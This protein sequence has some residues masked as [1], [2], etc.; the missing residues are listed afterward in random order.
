MRQYPEALLTAP[1]LANLEERQRAEMLASAIPRTLAKG[2]FLFHE[3]DR[4]ECFFVLASGSIKLVRFTPQGKEML[5][6]MVRPGQTFAEA[7]VFGP[8]TYP[9]TA[10]AVELCE[11]WMWPLDRLLAML[12]GTPELALALILSVSVWTRHLVG[13]LEFLTQ[14]R[15]E[16]RLAVYL[17][18][19]AGGRRLASGDE[20]VL[21]EAKQLI[22]AQIGTAP[23][24]LSRTFKRL[25]EDGILS[26]EGDRVRIH[27]GEGLAVLAELIEV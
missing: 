9:A 14:R 22:A 12:R 4:T 20:V 24:V 10:V 5:V 6:H 3:G 1:L 27:D 19:R 13:K 18:G 11:V 26:V 21:E 17:L 16:E 2:Q 25:E 7:A 8:R 15:V 23:E